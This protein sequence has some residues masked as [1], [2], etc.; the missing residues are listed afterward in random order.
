VAEPTKPERTT[1]ELSD[2]ATKSGACS[3]VSCLMW[4]VA[5]VALVSIIAL[6]IASKAFTLSAAPEVVL[7]T[8]PVAPPGYYSAGP[9]A[10]GAGE[11]VS[12]APMPYAASDLQTVAIGDTIVV[13]GGFNGTSPLD[14]V[15][16]FDTL[17]ERF[18]SNVPSLPSPRY[19]FGAAAVV[20]GF[21]P[22]QADTPQVQVL[23]HPLYAT[24]VVA[25]GL[26]TRDG[27]SLT[28]VHLL[29]VAVD[30]SNSTRSTV[31]QALGGSTWQAGPALPEARSDFALVAVHG[32]V[33]LMGGFNPNYDLGSNNWFLAVNPVTG[34]IGAEWT[35]LASLMTPRGD[36]AA[37]ASA[38]GMYA[39]LLGG[40]GG[41][42]YDF[43][44]VAEVYSFATNSWTT[45]DPLPF[46][47]GDKAAVLFKDTVL[48]I[49]GELTSGRSAPC[50]FDPSQTCPVNE[51][52][53]HDTESLFF[54]PS[55]RPLTDSRWEARAPFPEA[56]FRLSAA[57]AHGVVYTFGGHSADET[58]SSDVWALFEPD[59]PDVWV[60][61]RGSA[62]RHS[63]H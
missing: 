50:D 38:D 14:R 45:V 32:G 53:I 34:A 52:A 18:H 30:P 20:S 42:D 22:S 12:K 2:H 58:E 11:W 35:P 36:V 10:A 17:Y 19:R 31:V 21:T 46:A 41:S 59:A 1:R 3:R 47:R 56:R 54:N 57:V 40:W 51:V 13:L 43:L 48:A 26:S 61:L 29:N 9:L 4:M 63:S 37:V 33:L 15:S 8:S 39:M 55:L 44:A 7:S 62:P 24:I 27:S 25:G 16:A 6:G 5:A 60:H 28:S 49:G 23:T